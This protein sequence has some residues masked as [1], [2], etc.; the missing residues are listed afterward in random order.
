MIDVTTFWDFVAFR[1]GLSATAE[2]WTRC[3]GAAA[4]DAVR[5][6]LLMG[7][8]IARTTTHSDGRALKVV[9]TTDGTYRLVCGT[10]GNVDAHGIGEHT[11]TSYAVNPTSL[12][13]MVAMSL[14]ITPDPKLVRGMPLAFAVGELEATPGTVIPVYMMLPP[15]NKLLAAETS[16]LLAECGKGFLLLVPG[17]PKLSSSLRGQ[18][19]RQQAMVIPLREVLP[20]WND[21]CFQP[22]P[23]W[24][25]YRDAYCRRHLSDR[26]VPAQ[27]AYQFARKGMWAIRFAGKDTYLEGPLKG[28][29][30]IHHLIAHRGQDIHVIRM[31]ADVA[32]EERKQVNA[33]AE[34]LQIASGSRTELV[35]EETI[36]K[37]RD[38]Y[39]ALVAEREHADDSRLTEIDKEIG[40]IAHYLSASLGLGGK[41][42]TTG[43]EVDKARRRIARV[44]NTA[45]EKIEGNDPDLAKHLRNSIKTNREMSYVPDREV[46]WVLA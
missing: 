43:D 46:D 39:D 24:Q 32:G 8:G 37:C 4:W 38:K 10:T 1:P 13:N 21:T 44:I 35:D 26:M 40:Q 31:L 28:A 20:S 14:A 15:T 9:P 33:A 34:G 3:L 45:I 42:R 17:Q 16:R 11:V 22:S 5:G 23:V 41:S 6:S 2:E 36:K 7:S 18:I 30:F 12:R 25:T 19:D 29:T 27:P